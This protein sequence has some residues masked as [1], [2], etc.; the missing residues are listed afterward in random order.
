MRA[1]LCPRPWRYNSYRTHP[2]LILPPRTRGISQEAAGGKVLEGVRWRGGR[3]PRPPEETGRRC[4]G[5][6]LG[7]EPR[8]LMATQGGRGD[9]VGHLYSLSG[10][11]RRQGQSH[12][13]SFPLL[14]L[15]VSSFW[16]NTAVCPFSGSFLAVLCS[17]GLCGR[18]RHLPVPW[19]S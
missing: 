16:R 10:Q 11:G 19:R 14:M 15:E 17:A 8:G 6:V 18:C 13:L 7:D 3:Q 2:A 5:S 9:W 12:L 1:K 4:W